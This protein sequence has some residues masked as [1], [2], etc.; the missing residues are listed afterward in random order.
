[1]PVKK[2]KQR[3]N[4][5]PYLT[6]LSPYSVQGLRTK[7]STITDTITAPDA[8]WKAF[9][10]TA[11]IPDKDKHEFYEYRD[12]F[13]RELSRLK[14]TNAKDSR[15]MI[16]IN[17]L[18]EAGDKELAH[19]VENS[20]PDGGHAKLGG[21][22]TP[23][24]FIVRVYLEQGN[25]DLMRKAIHRHG[26]TKPKGYVFYRPAYRPSI[27]AAL[28]QPTDSSLNW[29]EGILEKDFEHYLHEKLCDIAYIEL[30]G[31]WYFDVVHGGAGEQGEM[32]NDK[33]EREDYAMQRPEY[34][35]LV[36]NPKTGEMMTHLQYKR[37]NITS[38]YLHVFSQVLFGVEDYWTKSEQFNIHNFSQPVETIKEKLLARGSLEDKNPRLLRIG[39][40]SLTLKQCFGPTAEYGHG[41]TA[42]RKISDTYCL[43]SWKKPEETLVEPGETIESITLVFEFSDTKGGTTRSSVT[44]RRNQ[45]TPKGKMQVVGLNEWMR[46]NGLALLGFTLEERR[47]RF[48]ENPKLQESVPSKKGR[49]K[50][51]P[52]LLERAM[53]S[54]KRILADA[55][56][57]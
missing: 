8:Q 47:K 13:G 38:C 43:T 34:D 56:D 51:R 53:T 41:R 30:D 20:L 18:E 37:Q 39:L 2:V 23:S 7:L 32:I 24:D 31:Y 25:L 15:A 55:D 42:T 14:I 52:T 45:S 28:R 1:M 21:K 22:N 6:T 11:D 46:E 49:E 16:E 40:Q 26:T 10:R 4:Y 12:E 17:I 5:I 33:S 35:T 9:S 29:A 44:L 48:E 54:N 27:H 50:N 57:K 36:F 3:A 19:L